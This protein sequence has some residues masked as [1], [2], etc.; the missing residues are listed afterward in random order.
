MLFSPL[1]GV[2][3]LPEQ[4]HKKEHGGGRITQMFHRLLLF[5]LR[6]RLTVIAATVGIFLLSLLG[7]PLL[8][9]QFF[10]ASDRPELVLTVGAASHTSASIHATREAADEVEKLLREDS[11]RRVWSFYIGETPVRFYLPLEPGLPNDF[12]AA[13]SS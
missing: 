3:L 7:L 1:V 8:K 6:R 5:S 10:P 9:Q 11:G 13:R 12:V 2:Y 4:M